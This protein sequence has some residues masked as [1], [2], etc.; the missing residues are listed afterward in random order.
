LPVHDAISLQ[1]PEQQAQEVAE[2]VCGT[3]REASSET[4]CPDF[5]VAVDTSI[6]ERWGE[7]NS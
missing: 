3:M 2:T 1:A 7:K 5:P 6:S 4:L